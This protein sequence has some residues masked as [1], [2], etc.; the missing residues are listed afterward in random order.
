M[1]QCQTDSPVTEFY[2]YPPIGADDWRYG[3]AVG[4]IRAL[5]TRMLTRS[6]LL[7]LANAENF[8]AA[9][10]LLSGTDYALPVGGRGPAEVEQMLR[11][12]R[13]EVRRRFASLME[14]EL[15]VEL[16]EAR[17]DFAN[18]RLAIRRLVT[19]R[20]IG[21]DYSVDGSI[22]A[23]QFEEILQA[24]DYGRFPEHLQEAVESAVL[25]Y[26]ES[27]D[28]RRI[29]Y[30][31][32]KAQ[33]VYKLRRARELRCEFLCSLFRIQIDLINVRMMLRLKA[34]GRQERHLFLPEGF[35]EMAKYA[36]ALEVGYEAVPPLFFATPYFEL[37]EGGIAY[38]TTNQSF[39]RLER[40]CEEYLMGYLRQTAALA[41]G[42]QPIVAYLLLMEQEIRTVR[43]ILTAKQNG[44][45]ARLILDRLGE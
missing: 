14:D 15:L 7:D 25:G 29:D 26:Y 10:E 2:R 31:L 36:H 30:E 24:E 1:F 19:E 41:A 13:T 32:D 6:A 39:L 20:P 34:A 40:L 45:E 5:E 33:A 8:D 17:D 38:W 16:L 42:W 28:I 3:F 22:P 44:M 35:V 27:K 21:A 11:D 4:T 37:V 23:E 43:M 12:R 9:M 18:L